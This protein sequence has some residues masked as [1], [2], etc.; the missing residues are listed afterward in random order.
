M[1]FGCFGILL[2]GWSL[3][4]NGIGNLYTSKLF[5]EEEKLGFSMFVILDLREFC[6]KNY[7]MAFNNLNPQ[8]L[9]LG[10]L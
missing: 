9:F 5:L 4:V 1:E 3:F 10:Q 7:G 6:V 2:W 8:F